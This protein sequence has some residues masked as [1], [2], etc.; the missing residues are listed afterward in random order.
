MCLLRI[1]VLKSFPLR[2]HGEVG[3][4]RDTGY[5][6]HHYNQKPD[7]NHLAEG[8]TDSFWLMVSEGAVHG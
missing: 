5:F 8:K 4:G 3:F 6:S 7:R 2:W 1:H